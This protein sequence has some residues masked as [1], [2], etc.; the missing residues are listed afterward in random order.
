MNIHNNQK[1][2]SSILFAMIFTIIISLLAVG[3]ATLA[4]NDQRQA[5]DQS[6]GFQAQYA[7]E[8]AIN[9]VAAV[10]KDNPS[11]AANANCGS[12]YEIETVSGVKVTC[13]TWTS[14][15]PNIIFEQVSAKPFSTRIQ[16]SGPYSNL[17]FTWTSTSTGTYGTSGFPDTINTSN[18]PILKVVFLPDGSTDARTVYLV[19]SSSG[20]GNVLYPTNVTNGQPADTSCNA[21]GCV[22]QVAV[23]AASFQN[24]YV[25]IS[26]I[27]Q[28]A[29]RVTIEAQQGGANRDLSGSQYVIDATAIAQDITK[30]VQARVPIG[31]QTW[32][33]GVAASADEMCKDIKI[34]GENNTGI[35]SSDAC[36][37]RIVP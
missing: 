36:A 25:S 35:S 7:A 11:T 26:T 10:L 24:G 4:R 17:T 19:P 31:T 1:G 33:P 21:S 27:G 9:Q 20:A 12:N 16:A 29:S 2:M 8:T 18:Y 34:D 32:R 5:L 28:T 3:F 37:A 15:A 14:S 22:M 6:L 30:R 23:D 13:V